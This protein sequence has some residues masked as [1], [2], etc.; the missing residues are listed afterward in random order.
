[1]DSDLNKIFRS[2]QRLTEDHHQFFLYQILL[3]VHYIH[4]AGVVH[5]DLKPANVLVN[6]NCDVKICDF[7]LARVIQENERHIGGV[8]LQATVTEEAQLTDYV[9][10]RWWRAPEVVLLS[11]Q[12]FKS[13]DM[14]SV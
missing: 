6:T 12:F 2:T 5:R 8:N 13:V 9:C 4:S 3:A 10:T 7:G 14:W 1:M 11:G